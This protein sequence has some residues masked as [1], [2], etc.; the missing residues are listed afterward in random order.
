MNTTGSRT[1]PNEILL[2]QVSDLLALGKRVK[3]RA[4]GHSMRPFIRHGVDEIEL[5]SPTELRRGDIALALTGSHGYVLHRI[6]GLHGDTVVL[7]GDGN[8]YQEERCRRQD[9]LGKA[10]S[11]ARNGKTRSL[12]SRRTRLAAG[13]WRRM[14]PLRRGLNIIKRLID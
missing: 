1:V 12:T 6:V 3:L 5:T 11:A 2:E 10:V 4:N 14:L 8:L 13:M 7:A 9:V